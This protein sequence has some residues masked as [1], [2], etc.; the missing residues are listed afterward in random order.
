[1]AALDPEIVIDITT[2]RDSLQHNYNEMVA[3]T[4]GKGSKEIYELHLGLMTKLI[5]SEVRPSPAKSGTIGTVRNISRRMGTSMVRGVIR[6]R[7]KSDGLFY[8]VADIWHIGEAILRDLHRRCRSTHL[9]PLY[10]RG[11]RILGALYLALIGAANDI[12]TN[13]EERGGNIRTPKM[14][15]RLMERML[16]SKVRDTFRDM[17]E[18]LADVHAIPLPVKKSCTIMGGY[19]SKK[20]VAH[21]RTKTRRSRNRAPA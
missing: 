12:L 7:Y 16:R 15:I 4:H 5:P 14:L 17:Q 2:F 9:D 6:T 3:S 13:P 18:L 11:S 21:F 8:N 19:S 10:E 1:M 20:S